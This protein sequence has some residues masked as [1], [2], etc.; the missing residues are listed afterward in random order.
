MHC[1][2][3]YTFTENETC[4]EFCQA[5]MYKWQSYRVHRLFKKHERVYIGLVD[6]EIAASVLADSC[7]HKHAQYE[8]L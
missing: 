5:G 3:V 1:T 8:P 2:S 7:V 6:H 4:E